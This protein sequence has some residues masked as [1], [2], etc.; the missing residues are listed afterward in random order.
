MLSA[1]PV[2]SVDLVGRSMD[3]RVS[4]VKPDVALGSK[5]SRVGKVLPTRHFVPIKSSKNAS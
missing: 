5:N 4:G 3:V 2:Y 1:A